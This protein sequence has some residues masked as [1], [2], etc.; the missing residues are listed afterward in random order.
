M[1][2]HTPRRQPLQRPKTSNTNV[3]AASVINNN[4]AVI[5]DNLAT[6]N[7]DDAASTCV[8][9]IERTMMS[10][11]ATHKSSPAALTSQQS[12]TFLG[13]QGAYQPI[14]KGADFLRVEGPLTE[15]DW[16]KFEWS[17]VGVHKRMQLT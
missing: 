8:N 14:Q 3:N 1:A 9:N 13:L 11:V 6:A 15:L 5:G 16:S 2:P 10:N 12:G 7:W 4:A 17:F